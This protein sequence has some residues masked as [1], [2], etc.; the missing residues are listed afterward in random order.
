[1][2]QSSGLATY[3]ELLTSADQARF[4]MDNKLLVQFYV[5][6]IHNA[7]KSAEQGRPIYEEEEYIKVIIPGDS[8]TTVDC[9]VDDTFRT[10]FAKQYERFKKGIAEAVTGTPLEMWPQMSVGMVAE[11]KAI[12]VST[13]EQLAGLSDAVSQKI[14]GFHDL[15]RKAQAF[16][17]A[18]AG[19]A[20]NNKLQSELEKRDNEIELLKAQMQQL[21]VATQSKSE[22]SGNRKG[23]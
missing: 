11:M 21:L 1:M 2:Q 23:A 9:P 7:F 16:L 15:R 20:V 5:R 22:S 6:P 4:A 12:N 18:A 13:V 14:M 8:K 3:D 19:E 17:D 10:R